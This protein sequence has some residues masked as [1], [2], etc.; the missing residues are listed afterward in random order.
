MSYVCEREREYIDMCVCARENPRKGEY[1]KEKTEN[2]MKEH[3]KKTERDTKYLASTWGEKKHILCDRKVSNRD[4]LSQLAEGFVRSMKTVSK[5]DNRRDII[6]VT[7][8]IHRQVTLRL[9]HS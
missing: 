2:K 6:N 7:L 9:Q 8:T 4:D 1:E 3:R 5:K